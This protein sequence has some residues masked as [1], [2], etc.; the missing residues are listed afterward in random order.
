M[1]KIWAKGKKQR[2]TMLAFCLQLEHTDCVLQLAASNT[3]RI[4]LNGEFLT[5]GPM[6]NAHGIS[7]I[8]EIP[9]RGKG[10]LTIE[11]CYYGI[12]S[13]SNVMAAPFFAAQVFKN[14][15]KIADSFDFTCFEMTDKR[16]KVQRY[17]VQRP[18]VEIYDGSIDRTAFY[19]GEHNL[20][21]LMTIKTPG[22]RLVRSV[23]PIPLK[24]E[25]VD[26][27][28]IERGSVIHNND[29]P[30]WRDRCIQDVPTHWD[31][32][33][34]SEIGELISDEVCSY[35]YRKNSEGK[36][37]YALYELPINYSGFLSV[38]I[39]ARCKCCVTVIFDEAADFESYD[40]DERV[41]AQY[42]AN[43][44]LPLIF[45]RVN[46]C[47]IVRWMVNEGEHVLQSFEPYTFKYLKVICDGDVDIYGAGIK[48]YENENEN[49]IK[50]NFED[51]QLQSIMDAAMAT[52]RQNAVDLF[53]DCPG[54]ER[55]GY[56]GDMIFTGNAEKVVTGEN[57]IENAHLNMY[58]HSRYRPL[59]VPEILPMCYPSDHVDGVF[60]ITFPCLLAMRLLDRFSMDSSDLMVKKYEGVLYDTYDY[61]AR[62][63]NEYGLLENVGGAIF[64]EYTKSN[65]F[66]GSVS[67]VMNVLYVCLL[68]V[69]A[70]IEKNVDFANKAKKVSEA[71]IKYAFDGKY[72]RDRLQ[73]QGQ[74][75]IQTQDISET[76]QYYMLM[77]G[78]VD[79]ETF[80][81]Y[82]NNVINNF[83]PSEEAEINQFVASN[84]FTGYFMR[85]RYLLCERL[86]EQLL[87]DIKQLYFPMAGKTG[88]LWEFKVPTNSLNH[89]YNS[90]A[91]V[92]IVR[93]LTGYIDCNYRKK[94]IYFTKEVCS[95][96]T[97]FMME[98]PLK[99]AQKAIIRGVDG[100]IEICVPDG[101]KI[102][103]V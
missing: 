101:Y 23:L 27:C 50:Y 53:T 2:N 47:N 55:G 44:T 87:A 73:R 83:G 91:I 80:K 46:S 14:G 12:Y 20:K 66:Q 33:S 71:I 63:E 88:T 93:A 79:G 92:C 49:V 8:S 75:L 60:I 6:R 3:F 56:V 99:N 5:Y 24:N 69:L 78:I 36:M 72:F 9:L 34:Q 89:G 25:M 84:I 43:E 1:I 39:K 61:L 19:K 70:K 100:H 68:E 97:N 51:V 58:L 4:C 35:E 28:E 90:Y 15:K 57:C 52:Y 30:L 67:T 7:N 21:Q 64:I 85:F 22:N 29:L 103:Y 17:C 82:R 26:G 42:H 54:R 81:D 59:T 31:G 74:E 62:F 41:V 10:Y 38:K 98:L 95:L 37:K 11:V 18:F 48:K 77:S 76:C 94:E 86:Y 45:H 102:L 13:Y 16:K 32:Y 40:N 96:K 65:D